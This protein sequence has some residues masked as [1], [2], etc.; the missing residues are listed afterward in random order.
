MG[1]AAT[2]AKRK[3]NREN[4]T[5]ITVAMNPGLAAKLKEDCKEKSVSVSSVITGLVTGYLGVD[6]PPAK[7][8]PQE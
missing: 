1:T 6:V 3:W 7:E 5:N 4:Y 8:K 2:K